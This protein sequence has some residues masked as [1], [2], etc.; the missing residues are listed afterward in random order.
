MLLKDESKMQIHK[1]FPKH[2]TGVPNTCVDIVRRDEYTCKKYKLPKKIHILN[3]FKSCFYSIDSTEVT[4]AVDVKWWRKQRE[5]KIWLDQ[6]K[7]V[8]FFFRVTEFSKKK[9]RKHV[10]RFSRSSYRTLV[11]V[12]R[13]PK[14]ALVF[15]GPDSIET[16]RMCFLFLKM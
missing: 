12:C 11:G 15:P 5:F 16:W 14:S 1:T 9:D 7:K 4:Q 3:G 8:I 13:S 6:G 10:F 2:P